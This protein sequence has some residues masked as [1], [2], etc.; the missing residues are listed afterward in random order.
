[1][2]K[3]EAPLFNDPIFNGAAD[4]TIF[5]NHEEK[6]WWIVYTQRMHS[7]P[8]PG[9]TPIHGSKLGVASSPDGHDWLYRG[10][11]E[12]LEF[13][14]GHNTWWAPEII[15]YKN[16]YH[17]YASYVQGMP[18]NWE[19]PR[20]IIHYTSLNGWEW[21]FESK[22]ELSSDRVIDAC[23]AKLPSGQWRMWYKDER[24]GSH[25]YC[26]DSYDLYN[27]EVVGCSVDMDA[28]EGA[29]VFEY[30]GSW[31]LIADL[32]RGQGVFQSEDGL[33]WEYSGMILDK[34]G[35]RE[36]DQSFGHHADVLVI[37]DEAYIIYFTHPVRPEG[38]KKGMPLD[39][40]YKRTSLQVGRL[41]RQGD[42]L[43]CNRD[44]EYDFILPNGESILD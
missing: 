36:D 13:E 9:T 25:S 41:H 43:V 20:T 34:P 7:A 24:H 22:L 12:G 6:Q 28:H 37:G 26:A 19:R 18:V 2:R 8:G 16:K 11:L 39:P 4:P 5:W 21:K 30:A 3:P 15:H 38:W 14:H 33:E 10:T 32:W 17:M 40:S 31:W 23:V 44:E 35:K 42:T 1:M 29:N 27:W